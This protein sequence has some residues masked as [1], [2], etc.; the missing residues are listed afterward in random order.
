MHYNHYFNNVNALFQSEI[1]FYGLG[2]YCQ[3][4]AIAPAKSLKDYRAKS[5]R[6]EILLHLEFPGYSKVATAYA[7]FD[8]F[9]IVIRYY[10]T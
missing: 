10:K 8:L 5:R 6:E 4:V 3:N 2:N 9:M 7:I 1:E